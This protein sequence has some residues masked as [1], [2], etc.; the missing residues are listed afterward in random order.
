MIPTYII[1]HHSATKDGKQNDWEAIRRY[2]TSWRYQGNIISEQEARQRIVNGIRGVESPW[3]DIGYHFGIEQE[4][5]VYVWKN[6]RPLNMNGAHCYELGMNSK[7][8]GICVVGN[9]DVDMISEEAFSLLVDHVD[10]LR[11]V[12]AIPVTNV[13][14]HS[15]F[16]SY[17]SCPGKLFPW[18]RFIGLLRKE[19]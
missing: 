16:A 10:G 4:N 12:Y 8:I 15:D 18:E 19:D 9:Y 17:K 3:L 13:K 2:H 7:A 14:R 6:G 1:I 5:G 11:Y